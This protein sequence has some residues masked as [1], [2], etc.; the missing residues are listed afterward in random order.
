MLNN[1][2]DTCCITG[3]RPKSLPWGYNEDTSSCKNF[4]KHVKAIFENAI[5]NGTTTFLDG[6]AEGFDMISAEI[7]LKLKKSYKSVRL[8]AVIPCLNQEMKWKPE[9]QKRYHKILKQCDEKIV[10]SNTF[11]PS[12]MNDR[13]KFMVEHSSLVIACFNGKPGGTANTIRFAKENRSKI[14]VINPNDYK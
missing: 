5:K 8:I 14:R 7:I 12:C 3:H 4:K 9:Q 11:T 6:M 13:N 2:S 10:L 1:K